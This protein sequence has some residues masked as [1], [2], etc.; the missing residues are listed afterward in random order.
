MKISKKVLDKF[1]KNGW[2]CANDNWNLA[3]GFPTMEQRSFLL[4]VYS[5]K[6]GICGGGKKITMK[7]V[8]EY[9]E[10]YK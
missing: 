5:S 3:H 9:N 7:D 2:G 4:K 6:Y 8:K 10:I 1:D